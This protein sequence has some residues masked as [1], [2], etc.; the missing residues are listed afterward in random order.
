LSTQPE[1]IRAAY[2]LASQAYAQKFISELDYKP[3]D[4]E[5]LRQF[6]SMVGS[7]KPVL[8][9]GCGPGH[10]TAHL[11]SLGLV[12]TGIDLSPRMIE[13]ASSTFPLSHFEVGDFFALP[14][15]SSSVGGILA[16][17]CIVHLAPGELA[18]AFEEMSRVLVGGGVLLLSFH[19]GSHVVRAENFLETSAVLD[20]TFFDPVD[21]EA[22]LRAVRLN[23]IDVRTRQPYE[24]EYPSRRCYIFAQKPRS[25]G[26]QNC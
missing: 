18:A 19:V 12:A 20:F 7:Q 14:N 10:T 17:Y 26:E 24:I 6:A 16:F 23:P 9:I 5:L 4:R 13:T 2:D 8:D 25:S 22:A 21:V 1:S 11:T 15:K 3:F